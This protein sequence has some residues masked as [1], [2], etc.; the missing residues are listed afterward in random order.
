VSK[1]WH[2]RY[3][4]LI[5]NPQ[6]S[7]VKVPSVKSKLA[8]PATKGRI[9][10]ITQRVTGKETKALILV[11]DQ[12]LKREQNLRLEIFTRDSSISR[13]NNKNAKLTDEVDCHKA[14]DVMHA[15][16]IRLLKGEIVKKEQVQKESDAENNEQYDR[17][18]I[19]DESRKRQ[20]SLIKEQ[21]HALDNLRDDV[22]TSGDALEGLQRKLDSQTKIA[23]DE[24][25]RNNKLVVSLSATNGENGMLH[26]K[27]AKLEAAIRVLD[28][29]NVKLNKTID[30][31]VNEERSKL[32][33]DESIK[34]QNEKYNA[35]KAKGTFTFGTPAVTVPV[36]EP[37]PQTDL[38]S[39]TPSTKDAPEPSADHHVECRIAMVN[40]DHTNPA[41]SKGD[42]PMFKRKEKPI[43]PTAVSINEPL[44]VKNQEALPLISDPHTDS[45][46]DIL[47]TTREKKPSTPTVYT[48][49]NGT[50]NAVASLGKEEKNH[51]TLENLEL[52]KKFDAKDYGVL[53]LLTYQAVPAATPSKKS[54]CK[55][56]L[57]TIEYMQDDEW[58]FDSLFIVLDYQT[59]RWKKLGVRKETTDDDRYYIDQAYFEYCKSHKLT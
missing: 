34:I 54:K 43:T 28:K 45:A 12:G 42:S 37:K 36:P 18:E 56:L 49:G 22:C 17:L 33:R 59:G 44:L 25:I 23:K 15:I 55:I 11:I 7:C 27:V 47:E 5:C 1:K 20:L 6:P 41:M 29:T 16:D 31:M 26:I 3:F 57:N 51:L 14:R 8:A 46:I 13:I 32:K 40:G 53:H 30:G 39:F 9:T 38:S 24:K 48:V 10:R 52:I 50:G 58:H 35:T 4:N 21:K 2:K 19:A